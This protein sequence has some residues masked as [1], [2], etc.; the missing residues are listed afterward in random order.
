MVPGAGSGTVREILERLQADRKIAYT[1][2]MSTMNNLYR[3]GHLPREQMG[4]AHRYRTVVSHAEHTPDLT[5]QTFEHRQGLPLRGGDDRG[6][7]GPAPGCVPPS[8]RMLH[9]AWSRASA[10]KQEQDAYRVEGLRLFFWEKKFL[11]RR[12]GI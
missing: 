4:K 9:R 10:S 8:T 7:T 5:R 11:G 2:A 6:G 1:T 3:K 12:R